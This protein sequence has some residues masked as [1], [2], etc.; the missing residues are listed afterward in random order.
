VSWWRMDDT[1]GSANSVVDYMGR[2]NGTSVADA[3]QTDAGYFGKAMSF[4]G[5][6]D[7]VNVTNSK[8]SDLNITRNI[9]LS[10]WV[11]V[12][13]D[14]ANN[15]DLVGKY[16]GTNIQY[17]LMY[18]GGATDYLRF[19]TGTGNANYAVTINNWYHVVGTYNSTDTQIYV[20]GNAGTK[21][22]S[23]TAPA[24]AN[25][26]VLFGIRYNGANDFNGSIDDVMIFNRS[27]SADEIQALYANT[28]V[29]YLGVNYTE[30]SNGNHTFKAYSQDTKGNVNSTEE[31]LITLNLNTAPTIE[32]IS[33]ENGNSTT[34]R[35][36]TFEYNGTD[37]EGDSLIY[38]I[39]ITCVGGCSSDNRLIEDYD[40]GISY[41][42]TTDFAYLY[43]NNYYYQW[44]VRACENETAE[45]YCSDW[46]SPWTINISSLVSINLTN[47]FINF[48]E[49]SIG[50]TKNTTDV[51]LSPLR[52][53]ND[54]N[55]KVNISVNATQLWDS[56]IGASDNFMAKIRAYAGNASWANVDW[57]QLPSITGA[58]VVASDLNYS[59]GSD[60]LDTDILLTVPINEAPG[61]R[62][63]VINFRAELSE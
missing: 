62:T 2:N 49:M 15:Y 29:K 19:Y 56:V 36:P 6:G 58:V 16:D 45:L 39:N 1:N 10:A 55:S 35:T 27:L 48:G 53:V 14:T 12:G 59:E 51:S 26:E 24:H 20:N 61:N 3:H 8:S 54:G 13:A 32:L 30:L 41:T 63:S 47:D 5:D 23:P 50:E 38:D 60:G 42:P 22:S 43:D 28:S 9:S 4:D 52:L 7:Y 21:A 40:G 18:I 34:D 33:P 11:Y 25:Q 17:L 46:A 31:R 44:S 57:F 37:S